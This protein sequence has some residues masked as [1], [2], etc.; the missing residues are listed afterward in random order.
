MKRTISLSIVA[1][2]AVLMLFSCKKEDDTN[3]DNN[4]SSGHSYKFSDGLGVLAAVKSVSYVEVMGQL[5]PTYVNTASAVFLQSAGS[6]NFV[7]AG[8]VKV[9]GKSLKQYANKSYVY[10]NLMDPLNFDGGIQWQVGGS[11]QV[12]AF[13]H[14]VSR[15]MP[16][17]SGYQN[18]PS[19]INRSSDFTVQLS[20]RVTNADSVLVQIISTNGHAMVIVAGNSANATLS[21]SK[22]GSLS[23]SNNAMVMVAPMNF[24][25]QTFDG[26]KMYFVNEF[27]A[28]KTAVKLE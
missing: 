11:G 25:S 17:F 4:Q 13:S 9:T 3:P 20:G 19:T 27:A 7:D 14:T 12:P 5:I 15:P 21:A 8:A 6:S 24:S 23:A 26:K 16:S 28:T 10:E 18:L 2:F 1:V 22:L